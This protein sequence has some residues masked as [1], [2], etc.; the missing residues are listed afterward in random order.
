MKAIIEAKKFDH[1]LGSTWRGR[2]LIGDR[3][4]GFYL[5]IDSSKDLVF[6]E[7][8]TAYEFARII[9]PTVDPNEIITLHVR[10]EETKDSILSNTILMNAFGEIDIEVV[11]DGD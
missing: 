10:S 2:A 9:V 11:V 7:T 1:E 4:M 6:A 5:P 8:A 3:Q